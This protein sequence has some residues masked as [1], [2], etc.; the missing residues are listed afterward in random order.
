M[1]A[2]DYRAAFARTPNLA[3]L[4]NRLLKAFT[5]QAGFVLVAN[6]PFFIT[7]TGELYGGDLDSP[8]F[9]HADDVDDEFVLWNEMMLIAEGLRTTRY[10]KD[11]L[12]CLENWSGKAIN[13][14]DD[15]AAF[16]DLQYVSILREYNLL[17]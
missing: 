8:R 5:E 15:L 12:L 16:A 7:K 2:I 14:V 6:A 3:A 10:S 9:I 11:D 1:T 4:C 13:L 17:N